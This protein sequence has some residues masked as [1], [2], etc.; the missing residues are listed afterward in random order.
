MFEYLTRN[1]LILAKT[2]GVNMS[3][4]NENPESKNQQL[5]DTISINE[6]GEVVIKDSKLAEALQELSP[7]EL[8]AIAG[9]LQASMKEADS[10]G[11]GCNGCGC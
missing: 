7:E 2:Q 10:N 9:G 8:D 11:S 6:N 3:I 1:K 4:P 5:N